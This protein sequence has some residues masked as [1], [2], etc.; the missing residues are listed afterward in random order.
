MK[1]VGCRGGVTRL[2]AK[3]TLDFEISLE[4]KK[5]LSSVVVHSVSNVTVKYCDVTNTVSV[6]IVWDVK[7]DFV[8]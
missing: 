2:F 4:K 5:K 7:T 1:L 3:K 8:S 6:V